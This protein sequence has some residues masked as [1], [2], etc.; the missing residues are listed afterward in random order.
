MAVWKNIVLNLVRR[1][2]A[3]GQ[4]NIFPIDGV[5][6]LSWSHDIVHVKDHLQVAISEPVEVEDDSEIFGRQQINIT[7]RIFVR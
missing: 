7:E 6:D 2:S 5:E 1:G 4:T 3:G